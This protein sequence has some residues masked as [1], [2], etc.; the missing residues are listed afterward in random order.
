MRGRR[1]A[2][3]PCEDWMMRFGLRTKTGACVVIACLFAGACAN[4][5]VAEPKL[6]LACQTMKCTCI[7]VKAEFLKKRRVEEVLW[8]QNGDAYCP[9]GFVLQ[10]AEDN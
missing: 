6:A 7:A 4:D 2:G 3:R 1:Y 10:R 8:R 5:P 9:E